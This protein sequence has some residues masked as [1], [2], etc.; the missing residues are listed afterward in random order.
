[1]HPQIEGERIAYVFLLTHNPKVSGS[2]PSRNQRNQFVRRD[3][4]VDLVYQTFA[5]PAQ[6]NVGPQLTETMLL[7]RAMN[8]CSQAN[9][10]STTQ[11]RR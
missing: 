1:M 3:Q 6:D 2:N 10:R 9:S 11:R 7:E 4:H 8:Q 5:N